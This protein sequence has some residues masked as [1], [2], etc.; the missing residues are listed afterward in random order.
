MEA[1]SRRSLIK[2]MVGWL[3]LDRS[4]ELR[5]SMISERNIS[6]VKGYF[7]ILLFNAELVIT[8]FVGLSQ[9]AGLLNF[10]RLI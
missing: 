1:S 4:N 8:N 3:I 2:W 5:T 9:S 7:A 10:G 6:S